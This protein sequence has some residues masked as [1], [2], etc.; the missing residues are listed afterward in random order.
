MMPWEKNFWH[1]VNENLTDSL[2]IC[3]MPCKPFF[4]E[5]YNNVRTSCVSLFSSNQISISLPFHQEHNS[6]IVSDA[7]VIFFSFQTSVNPYFVLF[8]RCLQWFL[9]LFLLVPL[10]GSSESSDF[11][12]SFS[13]C[14]NG[15]T[16]FIFLITRVKF[17]PY[18]RFLFYTFSSPPSIEEDW[19]L[20]E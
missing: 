5:L 19:T 2:V 11:S 4:V 12:T 13:F 8:S 15:Q 14:Y 3:R 16:I 9:R 1:Y 20:T 17:F 6:P 10:S 18:R 7:S